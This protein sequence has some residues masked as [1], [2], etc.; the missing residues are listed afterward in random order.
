MFGGIKVNE[1]GRKRYNKVVMLL[2]GDLV[3]LSFVRVSRLH[4]IGHVNRKE[5]KRKVSQAINSS[6]QGCPL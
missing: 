2:S 1:N 6:P 3:T 4:W 5:S